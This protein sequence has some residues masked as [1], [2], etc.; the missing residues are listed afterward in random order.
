M[1]PAMLVTQTVPMLDGGKTWPYTNGFALDNGAWDSWVYNL[2]LPP[3]TY[4]VVMRDNANPS[5]IAVAPAPSVITPNTAPATITFQPIK[6]STSLPNGTP[7]GVITATGGTP[8][9]ALTLTQAAANSLGYAITSL[10]G[11][12]WQVSIA[13][14]TKLTAGNNTIAGSIASGP[15]AEPFSFTFPVTTGNTIPVS[16]MAFTQAA[17]LTNGTP[18]GSPAFTVSMNGY[19]GGNF[20]ILSQDAPGNTSTNCAPRYTLTGTAGGAQGSSGAAVGN[21]V[22]TTSNTLS[23]Q[24]EN[25][26]ICW[27]AGR[28]GSTPVWHRRR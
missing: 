16:A 24:T 3:G 5:V 26:V 12:K 21:S 19:T 20:A 22:G 18:L 14:Q 1:T 25:L 11:G 6:F 13:D 10:G 7:I 27:T 8:H 17:G 28:T 4:N 23:A 9:F 15:A 2:A